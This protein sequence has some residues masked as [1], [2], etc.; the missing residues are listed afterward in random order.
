MAESTKQII[1][2]ILFTVLLL[3]CHPTISFSCVPRKAIARAGRCGELD[4]PIP[5]PTTMAASQARR[6][7]YVP[8]SP[9]GNR[10][11]IYEAPPQAPPPVAA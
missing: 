7:P 6:K 11:I 3:G 10:V 2:A 9:D 8:P 1:V 5:S 4:D